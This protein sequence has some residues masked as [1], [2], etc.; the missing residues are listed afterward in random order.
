[1]GKF[2]KDKRDIY[3]RKAKEEGYRARSA[4]KLLHINETFQ[5]LDGVNRVVDLCAAPGGWSEV[6]SRIFEKRDAAKKEEESASSE[7]AEK[8]NSSGLCE[9]KIIAV[10]LMTMAPI[11]GVVT[12]VGD[13]TREAT[14]KGILEKLGEKAQL[15]VCDGAPDVI[16]L[17]DV[18]EYVQHQLV[19]AA[20]NI[21]TNVLQKGGTFVAKIFRGKEVGK[22]Y[23]VLQRFFKTVI[24]SK[25]KA[26][27]NSSMEGFL[28]CKDFSPPLAF[29]ESMAKRL[30]VD[31]LETELNKDGKV[32]VQFR[33][34]GQHTWDSDQSY[35][36][37]KTV[38][39]NRRD[40]QIIE[41]HEREQKT[42]FPPARP[43][44][45]LRPAAAAKVMKGNSA[46]QKTDRKRAYQGPS[47]PP[48]DPP[49]KR[50]LELRRANRLAGSKK[51]ENS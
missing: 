40:E 35:P 48:I 37:D 23:R 17:H 50:F 31:E 42:K 22:V 44:S 21:T 2:S 38:E 3:Y 36:L 51:G 13:I 28:V 30:S 5:I 4:F 8:K 10:D 32:E 49:Y 6:V 9:T 1:M 26:C 27:R 39:Q 43:L 45:L 29:K 24:I 11:P 14:A 18:D 33:H 20:L 25:P 34:C 16:G 7:K 19:L 46:N 12:M 47:A 15:V 41:A